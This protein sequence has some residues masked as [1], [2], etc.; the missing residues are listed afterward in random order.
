MALVPELHVRRLAKNFI[1]HLL[2]KLY[3]FILSVLL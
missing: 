3:S 2:C 1:E